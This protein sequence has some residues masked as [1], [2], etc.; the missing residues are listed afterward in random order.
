MDGTYPA[1]GH[2]SLPSPHIGVRARRRTGRPAIHGGFDHLH[3]RILRL[4]LS[5]CLRWAYMTSSVVDVVIL[6]HAFSYIKV[7]AFDSS[8]CI[9]YSIESILCSMGWSSLPQRLDYGGKPVR[10]EQPHQV[11]FERYR[12]RR[13]GS[14]GAR[15]GPGAAV[16]TPDSCP[17]RLCG[18]PKHDLF[19]PLRSAP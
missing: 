6:E 16:D 19:L 5:T 13:S 3:E 7:L 11:I 4:P 1:P 9:F 14:P 8:L 17:Y 12:T 18:G 15:N 2:L 10:A